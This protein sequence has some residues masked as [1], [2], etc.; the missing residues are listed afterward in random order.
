M[1][2]IAEA[3]S[4]GFPLHLPCHNQRDHYKSDWHRYNLKRKV[5]E[6]PPVSQENFSQRL[7]AQQIKTV[8][9]SA[10]SAF[11]ASC[12][13]CGKTYSSENAYANHLNSKKHKEAELKAAQQP[14]KAENVATP[15]EPTASSSSAVSASSNSTGPKSWRIQLAMAKTEEELS[16]LIDQK[17]ASAPR[18]KPQ[19]CLFCTTSAKSLEEN[20]EHM[21]VAHSFFIPDL[22]FLVDLEGLLKYLGEK[23]SVR[24]RRTLHSLEA[25]RMHM[26]EKGHCKIPYEEEDDLDEVSEFYDFSSTWEEEEDSGAQDEESPVEGVEEDGDWEDVDE[27]SVSARARK[28]AVYLSEDG[29]ELTLGSGKVVLHRNVQVPRW[30]PPRRNHDALVISRVAGRYAQMDVA[31]FRSKQASV[32]LEREAQKQ[33]KMVER[34]YNDF[35]TRVG[36][37]GNRGYSNRFLRDPLGFK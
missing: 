5:A 6:L 31:A 24:K 23:V 9:E 26:T 20:V 11:T 27:E 1:S 13:A 3:T 29:S 22:E 4:L 19:D 16:E 25:V 34:S 17:L 35:R 14:K 7:A 12:G 21:A 2:T 8:E 28:S 37:A 32:A 36:I 15:T 33:N 10:R 30:V 18:L